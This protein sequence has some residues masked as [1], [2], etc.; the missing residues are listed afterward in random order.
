LARKKNRVDRPTSAQADLLTSYPA[1]ALLSFLAEIG[2][3]KK[4]YPAKN[5]PELPEKNL[6]ESP[7]ENSRGS[8]N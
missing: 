4:F 1:N 3:E 8:K 7:A 6:L 2:R 5:L